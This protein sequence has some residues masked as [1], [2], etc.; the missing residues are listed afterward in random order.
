MSI[1][2]KHD[3]KAQKKYGQNFLTDDGVLDEIVEAAGVCD[4]DHID[5]IFPDQKML[6]HIFTMELLTYSLRGLS[7]KKMWR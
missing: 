2:R 3:I 5:K 1:V 7:P 4:K 6:R